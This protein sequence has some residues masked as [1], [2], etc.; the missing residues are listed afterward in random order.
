VLAT[1]RCAVKPA[2]LCAPAF[3]TKSTYNESEAMNRRAEI[4]SHHDV[5]PQLR[6]ARPA[7]PL[8]RLKLLLTV[9]ILAAVASGILI[10][11]LI[12][13]SI[14]AAILLIVLVLAIAA[15]VLKRMFR[16]ILPSTDLTHPRP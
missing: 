4:V 9:V 15:L 1:A 14:L 13:G 10:A 16:R 6:S 12:L 11:G 7:G 8:Q 5:P 3:I 2:K